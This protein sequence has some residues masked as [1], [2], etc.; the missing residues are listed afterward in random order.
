M[1]VDSIYSENE[2]QRDQ[3]FPIT[4][5]ISWNKLKSRVAENVHSGNTIYVRF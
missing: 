4:I 1:L 2:K 3:M 5:Q